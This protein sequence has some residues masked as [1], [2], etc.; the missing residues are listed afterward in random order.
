MKKTLICIDRDGT[1]IHDTREHLFLG[2]NNDWQGQVGILPHVVEGLR[3]LNTI[4][5]A[6]FIVSRARQ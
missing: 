2:R 3:L 1:L 6:E 4:A 5:G